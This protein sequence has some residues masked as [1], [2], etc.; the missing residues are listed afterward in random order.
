M[1]PDLDLEIELK[2]KLF[3]GLIGIEN[4]SLDVNFKNFKGFRLHA[5][6]HDASNFEYSEKRFTIFS[7][8]L[9]CRI[10][11]IKVMNILVIRLVLPFC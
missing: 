11:L 9:L 8:V 2:L 10:E 1:D 5:I 4:F 3:G 6:L 7:Y